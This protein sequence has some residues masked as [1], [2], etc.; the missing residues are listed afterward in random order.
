M[1]GA[2]IIINWFIYKTLPIL[3]GIIVV[4]LFVGVSAL[5]S[6]VL[7]FLFDDLL[8]SFLSLLEAWPPNSKNVKQKKCHSLCNIV[9]DS[10]LTQTAIVIE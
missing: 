6:S 2:S 5:S 8:L 7:D 1:N 3:F 10:K 4:E 9:H